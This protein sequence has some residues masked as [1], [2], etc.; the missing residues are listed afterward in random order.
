MAYCS[1]CSAVV[2]GVHE[3][4]VTC[5]QHQGTVWL[6]HVPGTNGPCKCPCTVTTQPKQVC[7]RL[8]HQVADT[9]VL[10]C[11]VLQVYADEER[12]SPIAKFYGLRQQAEKDNDEPYMCV[13]DFIAPKG[14]GVA[15]Y[16]GAFACSAGHG[17]EK[18]VAGFKAAGRTAGGQLSV[19]LQGSFSS[20]RAAPQA[21]D[22]GAHTQWPADE[23]GTTFCWPP[24]P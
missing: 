21:C 13:S 7:A 22:Q 17:L 3:R 24:H 5:L 20:R 9:C 15:D 16:V 2:A 14:S 18:V 8:G 4:L 19:C 12:N 1:C 10:C 6:W 23:V 11:A